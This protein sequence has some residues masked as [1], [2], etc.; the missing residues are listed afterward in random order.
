MNI[1]PVFSREIMPGIPSHTVNIIMD[2]DKR[3]K[4]D[5]LVLQANRKLKILY[6]AGK[7]LGATLDVT[8]LYNSMFE[9]VSLIADCDDMFVAVYNETEKMIKY[10][11]LRSKEEE[12]NIDVSKIPPIPLAPPGF[13]I[14]SEVIRSG[15]SKL[16]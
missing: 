4:S 3:K 15:E 13:G 5:E 12:Q 1:P 16:F 14:L 10:S 7:K 11:Y 2:V 8:E 9:Y 6:E